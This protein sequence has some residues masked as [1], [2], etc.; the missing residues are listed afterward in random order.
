V[1]CC[2]G[3][4]LDL[5]H[6]QTLGEGDGTFP[7]VCFRS[8]YALHSTLYEHSHTRFGLSVRVGVEIQV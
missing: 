1:I 7:D 3:N 6:S 2:C 5:V 4:P 8:C